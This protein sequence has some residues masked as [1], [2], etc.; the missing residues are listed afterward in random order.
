MRDV[1]PDIERTSVFADDPAFQHHLV[2][3]SRRVAHE[4]GLPA[5]AAED[6]YQSV[7]LTLSQFSSEKIQN[8]ANL[9]AYAFKMARNEAIHLYVKNKNLRDP[10]QANPNLYSDGAEAAKRIEYRILLRDLWEHLDVE[11]RG[12]FQLI[13]FGYGAKEIANRLGI[14]HD[15]ARQKI[16]RFR[17]QL[18]KLIFDGP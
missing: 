4:L 6:I 17:K 11:D 3:A 10:I 2:A 18:R 13:I 1:F 14:S 7:L 16:V 12:I 15:S 8:I 5:A 9:K